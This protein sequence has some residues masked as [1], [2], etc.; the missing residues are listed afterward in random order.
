MSRPASRRYGI[1]APLTD[2]IASM[3]ITWPFPRRSRASTTRHTLNPAAEPR[4]PSVWDRWFGKYTAVLQ[5]LAVA[6]AA[7]TLLRIVLFIAFVDASE[8]AASEIARIFWVGF[9]FDLLVGLCFVL[10]QAITLTFCP[11]RFA[12]GRLMRFVFE[13]QWLLAF[14]ILPFLSVAEYLFF[15]EFSTRLNYIAFEYLVYPTEV[16]CNIYQSYPLVPLSAVVAGVGVGMYL[17]LRRGLYRRIRQPVPAWRRFAIFA[18]IVAAGCGLWQTNSMRWI[19]ASEN[20][21]ANECAANGWYSFVYYAWTCRFDYHDFYLT[22]E[23]EEA[24]RRVR[25]RIVRPQDELHTDAGNPFD[26]TVHTGRPRRD[27][28]VVIVL[29]ESLGSNF[30]GALG[31]DRHFTP[32]FDALCREGLLFDNF[33]ATGNRTARALEAVH[34]SLPP[35]PTESIL[36]RDHSRRVYTL[37]NVLARR[38]YERLFLDGGRGLFDGV[39]SFMKK[40]GYDRFIEQSDFKDPVFTNAWG[41]CDEDLFNR[42]VTELD[43]LHAAGRPFLATIL[44]VSNHRPYTYPDGRIAERGQTRENAVK[45][46]D[47][48]LG[49]FFRKARTKPFYRDTLFVVLGDHGARVYGRQLFPMKSYR[50]PVLM[51][52]PEGR[53]K[54]TRCH[55]LACTLDVGP[56]ILG[57]LGGSYRSVF[58]GRDALTIPPSQGYALMQHN[59]DLALLD[60]NDRMCVLGG[61]KAANQFILNRDDFSLKDIGPPDPDLL[62]DTI[63]FFQSAYRLYYAEK[64]YPKLPAE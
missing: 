18:G 20:R 2:I 39:R 56:T 16:C 51:I 25:R 6:V 30:I 29:E 54:G 45:Y 13:S 26:R 53:R 33:F 17:V 57:L 43:A 61:Q 64:L 42:A 10:I 14:L 5:I 59:H 3:T 52:L 34:A 38:G 19:H 48:A 46:A 24:T 47:W 1:V 31:D 62:Q 63:A 11:N 37:A 41:V 7:F 22:I 9:R 36:K 4:R 49:D 23:Q 8:L 15:S 27:W 32:H 50:V 40:N 44:T 58:Y 60:A 21:V 28:N 12:N 35:I 55:T